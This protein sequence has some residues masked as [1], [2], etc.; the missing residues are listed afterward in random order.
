LLRAL[1][2]LEPDVVLVEGPPDA[3]GIAAAAAHPE[4]RPPV[5]ILVYA[6]DA[7]R[8]AVFYPFAAFSP[9]WVA[10][11]YA[12]DRGLPVRFMDL[13][14]SYRMQADDIAGAD[15]PFE[16]PELRR[17][18][19]AAIAAAAGFSD[20]E[21]WWDRM[22]EHRHDD[23]DAFAALGELMAGVRAQFAAD[24]DAEDGLREA[25]M[26]QIVR[27][28]AAE[29]ERVAVVC[30][31][32]HVPALDVLPPARADTH[33]LKG[34]T[35]TKVAATWVP[36]TFGRLMAA[37]GYG[38]GITS[39]GWYEHLWL[40]RDGIIAAWMT[41]AARALRA[42]GL[43]ISPAHA[44]EATRLADTLAALR[45]V[46]LPGLPEADDAIRAVFTFGSTLPMALVHDELIVAERLGGVPPDVPQVPLA[47]DVA[48]EQKRLR[49]PPSPAARELDLDLRKPG[50]LERSHLLHRLA[51]LDIPW[52][53]PQAARGATGTFH[54]RWMLRWQ[55]EFVV[56]LIE[57][58]I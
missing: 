33:T 16:R 2:A 27:A 45:E 52:G 40:Q 12:L 31:A 15:E 1:D 4:M 22:V 9:E 19:L 53:A 5:A 49:L 37:S 10:L 56:S 29:Y 47:A 26:R 34:L 43:D 58:S 18:P 20:G 13:A 32:W 14:Q 30:G 11:R 3:D 42:A 21:R 50:D 7:P 44:I 8:R 25:A 48:R 24:D 38:A 51:L 36:W 46:P 28:A 39:P 54:E 6:P 17:D 41:K 57:A 35:R 55:P 23:A